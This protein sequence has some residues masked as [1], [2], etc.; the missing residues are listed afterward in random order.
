MI[1]CRDVECL[2]L[3]LFVFLCPRRDPTRA[4]IDLSGV[5]DRA[6]A[7]QL[8]KFYSEHKHINLKILLLWYFCS[9]VSYSPNI[10]FRMRYTL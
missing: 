9:V 2:V 7:M 5:F 6:G 10:H 3:Q 4:N 1:F 8:S